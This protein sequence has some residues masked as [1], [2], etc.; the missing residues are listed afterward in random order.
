MF[1]FRYKKAIMT[2]NIIAHYEIINKK[3]AR[4]TPDTRKVRLIAASKTVETARILPL[5]HHGHHDFGENRVVEAHTKWTP[6][7]QEFPH[8]T[9][10]L[11]GPLQTNKAK[12]AIQLFD[13]IHT[14]DREKLAQKLA[15]LRDAGAHLPQLFVQVNSGEEA[16]KHGLPPHAVKEFVHYC[17]TTLRLNIEGL[18]CIPPVA[19]VR[20]PHFALLMKLAKDLSLPYASMGMSDDYEMAVQQGATHIRIGTALFGARS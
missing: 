11:I 17:R 9:L 14:L 12:M 2:Q 20:P 3:I 13:V 19:D 6:L 16:Q 18:M 15:G 1:R 4:Y 8:V 5:L 10:H 7:K